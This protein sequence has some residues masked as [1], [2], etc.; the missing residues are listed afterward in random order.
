MQA[1]QPT[2]Q[3]ISHVANVRAKRLV[4]VDDRVTVSPSTINTFKRAIALSIAPQDNP[5]QMIALTLRKYVAIDCVHVFAR[6]QDG[7]VQL[8]N[9]TLDA[10]TVERYSWDLQDW[11]S[12]IYSQVVVRRPQIHI[13]CESLGDVNLEPSV[14]NALSQLTGADVRLR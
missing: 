9:V 3:P 7:V 1:V 11:F 12:H 5:F 8:G 4:V 14:L 6:C 2:S 13:H 10:K